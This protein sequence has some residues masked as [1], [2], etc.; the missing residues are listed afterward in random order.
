LRAAVGATSVIQGLGSLTDSSVSTLLTR[1][2]GWLAVASGALL[3]IG[4]LTPAAGML[5]ALGAIGVALSWF[6][7]PASNL[8]DAKLPTVLV[9]VVAVALVFLGPG[10]L[11]LDARL[12]GRREIIIPHPSHPPAHPPEN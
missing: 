12:F 6:P 9:V 8:F 7:A 11:S 5:V 1:A 2:A 4:F 10:A 3:L